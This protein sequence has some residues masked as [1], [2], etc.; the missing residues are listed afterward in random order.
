[1]QAEICGRQ[2]RV[3]LES[4]IGESTRQ[5]VQTADAEDV[6]NSRKAVNGPLQVFQE[7]TLSREQGTLQSTRQ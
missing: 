2:A 7:S 5:L 1:M 4:R 6:R 3:G